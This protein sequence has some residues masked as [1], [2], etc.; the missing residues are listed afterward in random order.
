MFL[1]WVTFAF[2]FTVDLVE[3]IFGGSDFL[4]ARLVKDEAAVDESG[5]ELSLAVFPRMAK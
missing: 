5:V 3:M 1:D 2:V 4:A